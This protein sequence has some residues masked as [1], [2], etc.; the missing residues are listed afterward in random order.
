MN[1]EVTAYERGLNKG[2]LMAYEH[3]LKGIQSGDEIR[4][5]TVFLELGI[6]AQKETVKRLK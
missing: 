4:S 3:I 5:I 2:C 1:K 6:E